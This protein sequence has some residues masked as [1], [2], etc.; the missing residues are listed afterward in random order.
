MMAR[1]FNNLILIKYILVCWPTTFSIIFILNFRG[2]RPSP[3]WKTKVMT[4]TVKCFN[5]FWNSSFSSNDSSE[6]FRSRLFG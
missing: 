1:K 4:I 2:Q 3:V 5:D 6:V